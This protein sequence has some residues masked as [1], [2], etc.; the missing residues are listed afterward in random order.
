MPSGVQ[1]PEF[2]WD[3]MRRGMLGRSILLLIFGALLGLLIML[4]YGLRDYSELL[5]IMWPA[6]GLLL[7]ALWSSP[8]SSW[9]WILMTQLI[10]QM[11]IYLVY[12][13]RV[14]WRWGAV[15]AAANSVDAIVGA[16]VARRLIAAPSMR[17]IRQVL[18]LIAAIAL[19]A[20]VSAIL[21]AYAS[22]HT[23]VGTHFFRQWQLWWANSWLGSLFLAPVLLTWALRRPIPGDA[24][25][26]PAARDLFLIGGSLLG[27]TCWLFASPPAA[28]S[29]ILHPPVL[30]LA[31]VIV[32]AF[33]LPPRWATSFT[34]LCVLLGAY[35]ASRRMGP[36]AG[37]PN[38]FARIGALQLYLS[39]LIV[40]DFLLA[41]GL[42]EM[43][44]T[45]ALLRRSDERYRNF[46]EKSSEAV[47][48][49]E[50]GIPMPIDL[51]LDAQ[52][53]WLREHAYVAECNQTYRRLNHQLGIVDADI[54]AWRADVPWSAVYV[55]HFEQAARQ[56]YSIDGLQFKISNGTT[57]ST[58]FTAFSGVISEGTLLRLCGVARDIKELVKLN[59]RLKMKQE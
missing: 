11:G 21:G 10:V 39:T 40:I 41:V 24:S 8:T 47:W 38:P 42:V 12:V 53:S 51:P 31:L 57:D 30:L 34:G 6:S 48:Q 36:F 15:F 28:L 35:F 18:Q 7:V 37:D 32:A 20:A 17:Q 25:P 44:D 27:F 55:D 59:H 50:L 43:R 1:T 26:P 49:G 54:R 2:P 19:G 16:V 3:F 14:N 52:I 56:A 9:I 13:D 4:G 22:I 45:V 29:P 58:Y 46:V 5:T 33:R 23:S